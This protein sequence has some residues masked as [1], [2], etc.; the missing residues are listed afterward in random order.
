[1]IVPVPLGFLSGSP[2]MGELIVVFCVILILFGPRRLPE[3]AR[4]IGRTLREIRSAS[5]EFR[6]QVMQIDLDEAISAPSP[7]AGDMAQPLVDDAVDDVDDADDEEAEED[8]ADRDADD[9][10]GPTR[11]LAG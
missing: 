1:M 11:D 8:Q 3:I 9:G 5:R 6:D 2:G 10:E 7:T 4:M